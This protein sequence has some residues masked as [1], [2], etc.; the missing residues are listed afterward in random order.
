M[1]AFIS[2]TPFVHFDW[3]KVMKK[4]ALIISPVLWCLLSKDTPQ[5]MQYEQSGAKLILTSGI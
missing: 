1:H 2:Q 5:L 4:N 3:T